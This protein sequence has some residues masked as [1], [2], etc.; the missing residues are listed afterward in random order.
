MKRST[1]GAKWNSGYEGTL[2][3]GAA[4]AATDSPKT[5]QEEHHLHETFDQEYIKFLNLHRVKYDERFVL[6]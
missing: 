1:E 4:A 2:K 3:Y 6:G 5:K